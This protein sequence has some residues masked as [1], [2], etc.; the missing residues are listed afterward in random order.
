[1]YAMNIQ[2]QCV[3]YVLKITLSYFIIEF[4]DDVQLVPNDWL[5]EDRRTCKLPNY[6]PMKYQKAVR[7]KEGASLS[8]PEYP[9][10]RVMRKTDTYEKGHRLLV[11]AENRSKRKRQEYDEEEIFYISRHAL[12]KQP[13]KEQ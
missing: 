11:R 6:D 1:M 3:M 8:W 5:S 7:I 12:P 9:V 4:Q 2:L 10:V 13:L